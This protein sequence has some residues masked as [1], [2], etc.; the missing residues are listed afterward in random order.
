MIFALFTL[1]HVDT[2]S[3]ASSSV[4]PASICAIP[5]ASQPRTSFKKGVTSP[6]LCIDTALSFVFTS[7]HVR[8]PRPT[9][10]R[11]EVFTFI[12]WTLVRTKYF[13]V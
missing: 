10:N 2:L 9:V 11:H 13:I 4:L 12:F 3:S 5:L 8:P 6:S 7:L 1:P